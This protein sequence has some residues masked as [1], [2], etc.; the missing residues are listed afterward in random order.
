MVEPIILGA[1]A[2]MT[3]MIARFVEKHAE[4]MSLGQPRIPDLHS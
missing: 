3:K 4:I 1:E 2:G